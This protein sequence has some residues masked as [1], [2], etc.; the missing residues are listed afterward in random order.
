MGCKVT[1]TVIGN[2]ITYDSNLNE[3]EMI[4]PKIVEELLKRRTYDDKDSEGLEGY[5]P[6]VL[7]ELLVKK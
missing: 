6:S 2:K 7:Y 4:L 5:I 3:S 1:L